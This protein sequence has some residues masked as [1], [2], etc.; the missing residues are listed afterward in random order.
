LVIMLGMAVV[1]PVGLRLLDCP[2]WIRLTWLAGSAP[3]VLALWLPRGLVA[4]G[5]AVP[6]A[7]AAVLLAGYA[8]GR[9]RPLTVAGLAAATA[10]AAPAVAGAALVGERLGYRLFGFPLATLALTV[11]HFHY[12]GFTAALV[13]ALL[14]TATGNSAPAR[15]A[16]LCVPAGVLLVLIG[17]FAGDEV[18]LAGAAVLTAGLW[19]AA[20]LTWR[21][22]RVRTPGRGTR[23]LFAIAALAPVASMLLALDWAA[24]EAFGVPHLSLAWMAGTHGLAN[25]VGFGLC[26]VLAWHR[27][28]GRAW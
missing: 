3:A 26:S 11:A 10:L 2:Q 24:G 27:V 13:A 9:L 5:L 15:A 28:R 21:Q 14:C 19:L 1:V 25:A 7:A 16:A 23:L 4:A 6:Y 20:G 22:V 17:F 8:T 12:A 18:Q